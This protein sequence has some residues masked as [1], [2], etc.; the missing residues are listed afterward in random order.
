[1]LLLVRVVRRSVGL[2]GPGSRPAHRVGSVLVVV[3]RGRVL[4]G[5]VCVVVAAGAVGCR[6]AG[7]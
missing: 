1:M 7:R 6:G 3:G 2:V 4:V 5:W